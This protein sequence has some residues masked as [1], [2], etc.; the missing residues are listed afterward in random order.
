MTEHDSKPR[1]VRGA[2]HIFKPKYKAKSGERR[3]SRTFWIQYYR[4]GARFVEN[5]HSDKVTVA[6]N[7]LKKK[8][9]AENFVRPQVEKV[10]L[11]ELMD[12]LLRVYEINGA[13]SSY[14]A[15]KKWEKHLKPFFGAMR[16]VD[17]T[18][19]QFNR[20]VEL[21]LQ[22]GAE[23]ATINRERSL[24]L[25]AFKLGC[26]STPRKVH[27]VPYLGDKKKENA[28][29][30]GFVDDVKYQAL[31]QHCGEPWLRAM[32]AA[33]YTFGFR[34]GELLNMRMRQIDL[35]DR[36]ID[37]EPGTT[38]NG[39]GRKAKMTQEVFELFRECVR[40]KKPDDPVFTRKNGG[41]V[42]DIR[43]A[44]CTLCERAELGSF[45]KGE[46]GKLRWTGL[47]FHDLR[48]SAVRN[49]VRCGISDNVAMRIS[50]HKTPSVF[51]RY[52]IINE[53]DIADAT[54]TLETR[55]KFSQST[56]KVEHSEG[57]ALETLTPL[58]Q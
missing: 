33:A 40:G 48:R 25:R 4:N 41:P 32:L 11:A 14:A 27:E 20:Y 36:I 23:N 22:Q 7:L 17:V 15:R 35:L 38:K 12:D 54:Q 21:R 57:P 13:A 8:L 55:P 47:L 30:Q 5:N 39:E 3:E 49:M 18:T 52:D 16:A 19:D 9:G 53:K 44:W 10:R 58:T 50:G 2:G 28:A 46:D 42:Q 31:C 56:T 45:T 29:R 34:K 51:K 6:R 37:L 26:R 43:D 1:G 24:L